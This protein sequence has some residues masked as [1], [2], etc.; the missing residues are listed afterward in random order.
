MKKIILIL[1]CLISLRAAAQITS[2]GTVIL[3]SVAPYY[4][5]IGDS[6]TI[7]F[8]FKYSGVPS[9]VKQWNFNYNNNGQY[10][11]IKYFVFSEFYHMNKSLIGTDTIYSFKALVPLTLPQVLM[12]VDVNT[13]GEYPGKNIVIQKC[14]N[15]IEQYQLDSI[16]PIYY[17]LMGNKID[18]RMNE[19]IIEQVGNYRRKVLIQE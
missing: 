16:T 13:S 2:T 14:I 10:T 1:M 4:A 15:G 11:Q 9:A 8:K 6:I 7:S 3:T 19:V 18:K 12:G 17:D 5:C